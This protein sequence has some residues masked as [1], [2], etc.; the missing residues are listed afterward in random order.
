M[1]CVL[2]EE[3]GHCNSVRHGDGQRRAD[4]ELWSPDT[5]SSFFSGPRGKTSED[6][7]GFAPVRA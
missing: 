3:R 5:G 6:R 2:S 7:P 1:G 4:A